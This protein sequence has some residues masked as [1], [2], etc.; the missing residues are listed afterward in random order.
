MEERNLGWVERCREGGQIRLRGG[1]K[2]E[3]DGEN[4]FYRA[5]SRRPSRPGKEATV[6]LFR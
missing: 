2:R 3:K 5:G 1:G 6:L 4:A